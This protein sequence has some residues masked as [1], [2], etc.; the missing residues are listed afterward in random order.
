MAETKRPTSETSD[1]LVS[2][3]VIRCTTNG[4]V[5]IGSSKNTKKRWYRH[6]S[7][8][9][10]GIHHCSHLQRAWGKYGPSAFCFECLE[11]LTSEVGLREREQFWIDTYR[12]SDR[13]FGF[14][15]SPDAE[16]NSGRRWTKEQKLRQ[17]ILLSGRSLP[18]ETKKRMRIAHTKI[19]H[20]GS[21][22]QEGDV[23][24]AITIWNNGYSCTEVAEALGCSVNIVHKVV[25]RRTWRN[26]TKGLTIRQADLKGSSHHNSRLTEGLVRQIRSKLEVMSGV[27][28]A[29]KFGVAPQTI[30]DIKKG[31]TWSHV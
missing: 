23:L 30:Y 16:R 18:E 3:Y 22:I 11:V 4:K 19:R 26:L 20:P 6:K 29:R 9:A 27:E 7:S 10:N 31:S 8:L 21:T 1:H 5:Y 14:N 24:W 17:S 28:I 13:R 2:V 12:A 15:L 25:S